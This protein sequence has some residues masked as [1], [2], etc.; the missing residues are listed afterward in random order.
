MRKI[1]LL[2]AAFCLLTFAPVSAQDAPIE[3]RVVPV[4]G[5]PSDCMQLDA[6]L[7]RVHTITKTADGADIKSAGGINDKMKQT[8]PNVYET[9]FSLNGKTLKVVADASKTPKTLQVSEPRLGCRWTA[10]AK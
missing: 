7:S 10:V 1:L 5:N 4:Q 8:S 3:F 9:S 6:S 2:P